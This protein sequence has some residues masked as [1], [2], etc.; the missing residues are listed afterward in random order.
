MMHAIFALALAAA[1]ALTPSS[2][3]PSSPLIEHSSGLP[4]TEVQIE[5]HGPY[6][7]IIDTAA[8]STVILPSLHA[9]LPVT[10]KKRGG[11]EVSGAAGKA[12]VETVAI[13][14]L[15]TQGRRFSGLTAFDMPPGPIDALQVHGILGADVLAHAILDIDMAA[16][17]W[18]I[19]DEEPVLASSAR[20]HRTAITLDDALAPRVTVWLDGYPIDAV[21][22]TGARATIVNWHAAAL[23]GLN[24]ESEGLRAGGTLKGVSSHATPSSVHTARKLEVAGAVIA[25]PDFRIADLPVFQTVGL[26]DKPGMILG[27]DHLGRFRTIIDYKGRELILVAAPGA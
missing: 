10:L 3:P 9:A 2:A 13:K 8:S 23:L 15:E 7:F 12:A 5:G 4:V 24:P 19:H 25:K 26:A 14:E 21:V 1:A 11:L 16:G 6:R 27:M 18:A 22:D 17:Q 20:E